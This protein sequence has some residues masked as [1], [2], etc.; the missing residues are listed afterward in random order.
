MP[1]RAA[2]YLRISKDDA[3]TGLAVERQRS[4]CL[5]LFKT[6]GLT[7]VEEY[8]D[9]AVSAYSRT[10]K[11]P[12][13]DKMTRDYEAGL[14]DVVVAWDMDRFS[15]QPA[16]LEKWIELGESRGL[17]IITPT[18]VTDLGTDN[19]RM[20]AR[21]KATTARAEVERKSARQKAQVAQA[22]ANGTFRGRVGYNDGEVIR[23]IFDAIR[24][25][26]GP[27]QIA[28]RLNAEGLTTITGNTWSGQAVRRVAMTP[29]HR[30]GLI[31]AEEFDA[32]QSLVRQ[33][34]KVGPKNVSAYS[35]AARC[36]TCDA[37]MTAS[38]P[39]YVCAHATNHPG[40]KGHPAI[41]LHLLESRIRREV[42]AELMLP[43]NGAPDDGTGAQIA[44]VDAKIAALAAKRADT[45]AS[46]NDPDL[47]LTM[48]DLK[49]TLAPIAKEIAGLR[50]RRDQLVAQNAT[51]TLLDGL[52]S[53]IV[54]PDTHVA[55]IERASEVATALG[56]RFDALDPDKRRELIVSMLDVRVTIGTGPERVKVWHRAGSAQV[57]NDPR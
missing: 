32:V 57:L 42:V 41:A 45:L 21:I 27:Y 28:K 35:G 5:A 29:R 47:A 44:Q 50:A 25:G 1:N 46:L 51:A 31:P 18:E 39:K 2:L 7:L 3:Q 12:K 56:K 43:G 37:S 4:E 19:G 20:F 22:K 6:Y 23:R 48:A 26:E 49:P 8:A 14:F 10:A 24:A 55:S 13:F 15:R 52:K 34:V 30:G 38:G 54:D 53:S 11:R 9:N 33:G 40:S 36:G 17:R 16:Q